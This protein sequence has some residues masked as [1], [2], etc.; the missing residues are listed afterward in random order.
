MI[1]N[2]LQPTSFTVMVERL[3]NV[4]FFVQRAMI[5]AVSATPIQQPAPLQNYY[6]TFDRLTYAE[7]DL[8]FVV[9]ERMNNY[10][11]VLAWMEGLGSPETT[12]QFKNL[13][14]TRD[15]AQSDITVIANNSHKNPNIK[16]TYKNCFPIALS[17][18][19]LSVV[20]GDIQYPEV[21]ATF[22]Y[23]TFEIEEI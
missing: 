8:G 1:T 14:K 3:P 7:F 17:S 20:A 23:D 6:E 16:I 2:Y 10:R 5:P 19:N 18:I 22:R 12:D 15:K 21:S 9:D 4:E 11:E 13:M